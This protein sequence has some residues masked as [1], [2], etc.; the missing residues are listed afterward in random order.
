MPA[1]RRRLA[2]PI[3]QVGSIA[4]DPGR[5]RSSSRARLRAGGERPVVWKMVPRRR[6]L[7]GGLGGVSVVAA[8]VLGYAYAVEPRRLRE[9]RF[10]LG[11][12]GLLPSLEGLRIA[13]LTDFHVGM[14]GTHRPT[15]RRAVAAALAWEPE[16]VALTGDFVHAGRWEA[17]ADLFR[18]LAAAAP[19]FAVLGNHDLSVSAAA[20]DRIADKL[21]AQG[22]AVLRN[23]HRVVPIR[24]RAEV[25]VVAVDDPSLDH[26][27]LPVAMLGLSSTPDAARPAILLGH[28][29]EIADQA[30]PGRF[31]LTLAG[32]THGGQIRMSPF[33][34]RTPLDLPMIAGGLDSPYARGGHVVRGNPL[35][36]NAGLGVSG[37]PF[38][39]LAPPEV[40]FFTLTG[41]VDESRDTDDPERFLM[42]EPNDRGR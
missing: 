11:V 9:R 29:P 31:V 37:I 6:A 15:L 14:T 10:R 7:L 20:T 26:D 41:G 21:D 22:V 39:F 28:A 27:D 40:V 25:V 32:H 2:A 24:D 34:R 16:L 17:G 23:E 36:V 35:Y 1:F 3:P 42:K 4:S 8:L 33:T 12:P 19:T 5:S 38:R 18:E 30:P 13:H